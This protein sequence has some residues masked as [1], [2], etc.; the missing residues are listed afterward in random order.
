[1]SPSLGRLVCIFCHCSRT[2]S[3][4]YVQNA[5]QLLSRIDTMTPCRRRETP[6]PLCH[7]GRGAV[8]HNKAQGVRLVDQ[9]MARRF[10]STFKPDISPARPRKC[11]KD[12]GAN[13]GARRSQFLNSRNEA[14]VCARFP[15]I[16]IGARF[17]A[18]VKPMWCQSNHRD[19]RRPTFNYNLFIE[20]THC[21]YQGEANCRID[22][23]SL[24]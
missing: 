22:S 18:S 14:V 20:F 19:R 4:N 13:A 10:C 6:P 2:M 16:L 17:M 1:M 3:D 7:D 8:R 5:R 11:I 9:N 21:E 24:Q 15:H 23:I 12:S